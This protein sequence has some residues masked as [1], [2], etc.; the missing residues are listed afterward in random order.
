MPA[1]P[2]AQN[3]TRTISRSWESYM[4]TLILSQ[5]LLFLPPGLILTLMKTLRKIG[6]ALSASPPKAAVRRM[7]AK[8]GTALRRPPTYFGPT[9]QPTFATLAII[10]TITD[11]HSSWKFA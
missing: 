10:D 2:S 1:A 8:T 5:H 11:W 6:A 7:N 9:R 4:H 3:R